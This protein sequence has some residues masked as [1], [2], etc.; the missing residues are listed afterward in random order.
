M[1]KKIAIIIVTY[2]SSKLINDCLDS[3]FQFNDVG[4][5]LEVIVVDNHSDEQSEMFQ[6]I[7]LKYGNKVSLI[8]SGKNGGYGFGNNVGINHTHAPI[9]IVM[10]PD[11]RFV[12]PILGSIET[13]MEDNTIGMIGVDFVDGSSPYYFKREASSVFRQLFFKYYVRRR[14]Y[15]PSTM[16]LSGSFLV[17]NKDNFLKVGAFDENIFMYSEEADIS[18]R[19]LRDGFKIIW[20]RQLKV[21]HLTH[22]RRFNPKLNQIRLK[23]GLYYE[24]KYGLDSNR[25]YSDAV[26]VLKIKIFVSKLMGK[27]SSMESFK[28]QLRLLKD[29]HANQSK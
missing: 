22:E 12:S 11:V 2:N 8:N 15:K 16:F 21:L 29:F 26:L 1:E 28:E 10:N 24:K 14:V 18:N 23:S 25:I 9:V 20:A 27:K 7:F 17:F 5:K 3:I 13:I 4:D 19:L 6:N